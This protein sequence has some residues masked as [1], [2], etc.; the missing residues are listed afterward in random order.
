M[1]IAV[2][3]SKVCCEIFILEEVSVGQ[4]YEFFEDG[5]IGWQQTKLSRFLF[6]K[7]A[8]DVNLSACSAHGPVFRILL[9]FFV[10]LF[11]IK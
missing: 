4:I 11:M 5:I 9:C 3:R 2:Y 8:R 7:S 1:V 6:S 10:P